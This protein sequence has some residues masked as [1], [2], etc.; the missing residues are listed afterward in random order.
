MCTFLTTYIPELKY[1]GRGSLG[2]LNK[3][4]R[5]ALE[6]HNDMILTDRTCSKREQFEDIGQSQLKPLSTIPF[7]PDNRQTLTVPGHGHVR[8]LGHYY[9][10]PHIYVGKK[11]TVFYASQHVEIYQYY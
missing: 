6:K 10:V 3:T 5:R 9:S 11:I 7:E 2:T 4:I 8:L 1:Q